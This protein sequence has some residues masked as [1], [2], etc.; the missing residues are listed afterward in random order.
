MDV[1]S[2][3]ANDASVDLDRVHVE[4][5]VD[6]HDD[7]VNGCPVGSTADLVAG[8]EDVVQDVIVGNPAGEGDRVGELGGLPGRDVDH[9]VVVR[10][11]VDGQGGVD[12]EA[13]AGRKDAVAVGVE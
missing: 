3:T 8:A 9:H 5:A 4:H 11:P 12:H 6:A 13:A 2:I 10:P 7:A 1:R